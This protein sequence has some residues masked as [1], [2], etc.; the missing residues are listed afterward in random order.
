MHI[1]FGI[2][3]YKKL[4]DW[5]NM[6]FLEYV[7]WKEFDGFLAKGVP[8]SQLCIFCLSY[9]PLAAQKTYSFIQEFA[10]EWSWYTSSGSAIF[11]HLS[12]TF[13]DPKWKKHLPEVGR[14]PY[15]PPVECLVLIASAMPRLLSV[16]RHLGATKHH[17]KWAPRTS[18]TPVI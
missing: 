3:L 10:R 6:L 16:H 8:P 17:G 11:L 2:N 15:Q 12:F 5:Y 7:G 18:Y 9:Q 13:L 4:I 14:L 1:W